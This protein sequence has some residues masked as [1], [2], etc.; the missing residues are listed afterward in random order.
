MSDLLVL[1]MIRWFR[2]H[3]LILFGAGGA[4][5]FTFAALFGVTS[6]IMAV[7]LGI[8]SVVFTSITVLLAALGAF[9]VILGLLAEGAVFHALARNP[10]LNLILSSAGPDAP[11]GRGP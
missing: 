8:P 3:P 9:L 4:T 11:R 2:D 5:A 1:T 7:G 10:P 6:I